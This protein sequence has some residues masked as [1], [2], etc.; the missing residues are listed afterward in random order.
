MQ[1]YES[2]TFHTFSW[3]KKLVV[4]VGTSKKHKPM[5]LSELAKPRK[6]RPMK[7][8]DSTAWPSKVQFG[9]TTLSMGWG[10][11]DNL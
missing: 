7:F 2:L 10:V 6:I 4:R 9:R 3:I 5:K 1:K 8:T 11:T